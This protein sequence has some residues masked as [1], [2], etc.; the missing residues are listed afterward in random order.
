MALTAIETLS[1]LIARLSDDEPIALADVKTHLRWTSTSENTLL[2]GWIAAA[3]THFEEQTGRQILTATW[4]YW[5]THGPTTNEIELPHPPLQTVESVTYDQST[6][7]GTELDAADYQVIAPAGIYCPRGRVVLADGVAWP[8]LGTQ[9]YPLRIRYTAGYGDT[10]ADVPDLIKTALYLLVGHFHQHRS[11]VH[12]GRA[13]LS[14]LP[15]GAE[16]I[17]RAFKYSAYPTTQ[18]RRTA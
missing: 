10:A 4:D 18:A 15:F 6:S 9:A 17:L 3:R 7:P 13:T 11:E 16:A 5:L 8:T 14:V 2:N 1:T 12:E